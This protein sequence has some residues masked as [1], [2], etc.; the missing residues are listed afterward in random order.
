MVFFPRQR[1]L[2]DDICKLDHDTILSLEFV[3]DRNIAHGF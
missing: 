1:T 3:N 2:Q